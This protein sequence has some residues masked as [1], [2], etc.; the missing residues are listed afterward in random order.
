MDLYDFAQ[1]LD[2]TKRS[3]NCALSVGVE[4]PLKGLAS[5][6][7]LLSDLD[8]SANFLVNRPVRSLAGDTTVESLEYRVTELAYSSDAALSSCGSR[9]AAGNAGCLDRSGSHDGC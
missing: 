1:L 9:R 5:A 3:A 4:K 6:I 2:V 7:Q 8:F